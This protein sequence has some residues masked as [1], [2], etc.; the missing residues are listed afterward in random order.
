[1]YYIIDK[2]VPKD[3]LQFQAPVMLCLSITG[4]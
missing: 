2:V 1:M 4:E 3:D